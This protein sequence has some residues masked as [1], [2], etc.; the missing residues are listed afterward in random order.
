MQIKKNILLS[1]ALIALAGILFFAASL[2]GNPVIQKQN[3]CTIPSK[4]SKNYQLPKTIS[5]WNFFTEAVLH[6][7]A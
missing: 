6:L 7:S 5:P 1:L 2:A 3:A 4:C